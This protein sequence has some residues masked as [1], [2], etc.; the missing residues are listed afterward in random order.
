MSRERHSRATVMRQGYGPIIGYC[1]R[2]AVAAH[3]A[4]H[5]YPIALCPN[6]PRCLSIDTNAWRVFEWPDGYQPGDVRADGH[7]WYRWIDCANALRVAAQDHDAFEIIAITAEPCMF[8]AAADNLGRK[9]PIWIADQRLPGSDAL[10]K[11]EGYDAADYDRNSALCGQ[12]VSLPP[13]HAQDWCHLLND[14]HLFDNHEDADKF[15]ASISSLS[16]D[17]GDDDHVPQRVVGIW[18]A[19]D[20]IGLL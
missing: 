16:L 15:C 3:M 14:S 20:R 10:W 17:Q 2:E 6:K 13:Q 18:R 4:R 9:W 19:I 5:P 11:L 12:A 1:V 7:L 8:Y